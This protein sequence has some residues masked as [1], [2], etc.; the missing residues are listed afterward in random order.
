[1]TLFSLPLNRT[2]QAMHPTLSNGEHEINSTHCND[3][4]AFLCVLESPPRRKKGPWLAWL[5]GLS[6]GL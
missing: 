2:A 6:A 5:S 1:M 4:S 3:I